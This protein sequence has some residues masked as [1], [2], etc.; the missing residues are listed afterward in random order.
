MVGLLVGE[1]SASKWGSGL[2]NV[3]IITYTPVA[4]GRHGGRYN[5]QSNSRTIH[6]QV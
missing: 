6:A 1:G 4:V 3:P 5:F 2:K